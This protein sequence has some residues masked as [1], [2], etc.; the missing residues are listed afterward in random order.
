MAHSPSTKWEDG[1]LVERAKSTPMGDGANDAVAVTGRPNDLPIEE[2]EPALPN[3][4]FAER[5]RRQKP[6]AKRVDSDSAEN[7]ALS[8][9]EATKKAKA[10]KK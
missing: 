9:S 3:T 2:P 5:A 10:D 6:G 7:K 4:T 8:S 1:R